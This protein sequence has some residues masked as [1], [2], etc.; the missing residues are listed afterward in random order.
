MTP[1][2]DA[3]STRSQ[4]QMP[5][6]ADGISGTLHNVTWYEAWDNK[7]EEIGRSPLFV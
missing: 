3:S 1:V 7:K 6:P 4:V 5:I 2:G